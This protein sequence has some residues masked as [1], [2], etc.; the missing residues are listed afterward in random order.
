MLGVEISGNDLSTVQP[1]IDYLADLELAKQKLREKHN[2][3][4][5]PYKRFKKDK[6][7]SIIESQIRIK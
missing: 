7:T 3:K 1:M 2:L 6:I 4:D 5:L